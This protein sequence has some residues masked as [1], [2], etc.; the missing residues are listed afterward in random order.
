MS[1]SEQ[2][3]AGAGSDRRGII[4]F[5]GGVGGTA[6]AAPFLLAAARRLTFAYHPY[7]GVVGLPAAL[8]YAPQQELYFYVAG[9]IG[10]FVA[11]LAGWSIGRRSKWLAWGILVVGVAVFGASLIG[12]TVQSAALIKSVARSA[13]AG[14]LLLF[15]LFSAPLF[16]RPGQ[17]EPEKEKPADFAVWMGIV[18]P[19]WAHESVLLA[20]Y[21]PAWPVALALAAG[22]AYVQGKLL[23]ENERPRRGQNVLVWLEAVA[24]VALAVAP[25]AAWILR[26]NL[27]IDRPTPSARAMALSGLAIAL[28][29]I[30][31]GALRSRLRYKPIVRPA[32]LVPFSVLAL[33]GLA[34]GMQTSL[35]AFHMGELMYPP[36]AIAAGLKPWADIFYV[37]GFGVDTVF[38]AIV[39]RPIEQFQGMVLQAAGLTAAIGVA[40]GVW[41]MLRLWGGR[42]WLLALVVGALAFEGSG[43]A[44]VRYLPMW[45]V[46]WIVAESARTGRLRWLALA[47]VVAWFGAFFSLDTGSTLLA[48][49]FVYVLAWGVFGEGGRMRRVQPMVAFLSGVAIVAAPTIVW[50]LYA[51]VLDDFAKVNW[52]YLLVK[53]HYDKIPIAVNS[54]VVFVSPAV[55]VAGAWASLKILRRGERTPVAAAIVLLTMIAPLAYMRA[56]DRSD[57]GHQIYG[58][59]PAWPLLA[60]LAVWRA[61]QAGAPRSLDALWRSA[62]FSILLIAYPFADP[63]L[64]RQPE[65]EPLVYRIDDYLHNFNADARLPLVGPAEDAQT[66]DFFN[67]V[68]ELDT[69]PA[70]EAVYDFSNQAALYA[71]IGRASPTRFFMPF[72]ASSEKWQNEVVGALDRRQVRWVLWRGPTEYWNAPDFIP[73]CVRQW[74]IA[75]YILEHYHPARV[76]AGNSVLLMRNE[77]ARS[78]TA[79]LGRNIWLTGAEVNLKSLPKVW[80]KDQPGVPKLPTRKIEKTFV[81]TPFSGAYR[82]DISESLAQATEVWVG[83]SKPTNGSFKIQWF[84]RDGNAAPPIRFDVSPDWNGQYRVMLSNMP[85]W[86]WPGPPARIEFT[87]DRPGDIELRIE[88]RK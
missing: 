59:V 56:F 87:A 17:A 41:A 79:S 52:Q 18:G 75:S 49:L 84:D 1:Q 86:V 30:V 25:I 44:T 63:L 29:P 51:G 43:W 70:G 55:T 12:N 72:Y 58:T 69:L 48:A 62:L 67:V 81:V 8:D 66:I 7:G 54:L 26:F 82:M 14:E 74:K 19:V 4:G 36:R 50:M 38:G 33:L 77:V 10:F 73:T 6:V 53:R 65:G 13:A 31:F 78:A 23:I 85:H 39:G 9:L 35:D 37:H 71:F 16:F 40:I 64:S 42:W 2:T 45:V 27:S 61:S 5:I 76:M 47:G 88:F 34:S 28:A 68:H 83:V 15:V 57:F 46:L 32:A 20:V 80:G 60:C 24:W 21:L 3:F 11:G 22:F